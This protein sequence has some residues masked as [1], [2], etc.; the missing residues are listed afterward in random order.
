[1]AKRKRW[2]DKQQLKKLMIDQHE[3][4]QTKTII[5]LKTRHHAIPF[6]KYFRIFSF[7]C[8]FYRSLFVLLSFFLLVIVL[9]VLLRF[10]GFDCFFLTQ[11]LM[12]AHF[13]IN[14]HY[15]LMVQ[16]DLITIYKKD[17]QLSTKHYAENW[18]Y[19]NISRKVW[20]YEGSNQN[21]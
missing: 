8:M 21:P 1:M 14:G 2:R 7:I 15:I 3:P 6:L 11:C 4:Y 5:I 16:T 17:K 20:R 13:I 10:T 9:P 12:N 19:R 18:R